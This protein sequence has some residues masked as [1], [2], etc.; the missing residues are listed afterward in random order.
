MINL[1]LALLLPVQATPQTAP[2]A[3]PVAAPVIGQWTYREATDATT[4]KKSAMAQVRNESGGRLV[5]RC[6]T[7]GIPIISVQFL[8]R[9]ALP[10]SD[11]RSVQVYYDEARVE[12]S[13]WQ[14]PGSGGYQAETVDVFNMASGIA[15]AK[16]IRV[17]IDNGEGKDPTEGVFKGPG[18][19]ALFRQVYAVCG[20][21][22]EKSAVPVNPK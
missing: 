15:G 22:Y 7:A 1:F 11:A 6:D 5:V 17:T 10:A 12:T 14:F 9:P 21:P 18:S 20:F 13:N 16:S 4:G 2:A 3:A 8:P 19:D